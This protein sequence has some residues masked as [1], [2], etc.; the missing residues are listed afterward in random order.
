[1]TDSP[2]RLS[3]ALLAVLALA[4]C[5]QTDDDDSAID[6]DDAVEDDDDAVDDDDSGAQDDDDA[7]DDDD[8]AD[9]DDA[10]DDDDATPDDCVDG[11]APRALV[12][13]AIGGLVQF[14][15]DPMTA[16]L[17]IVSGQ[18]L[19]VW[20][21][22]DAANPALFHTHDPLEVGPWGGWWGLA[23]APWGF[24]AVGTSSEGPTEVF[25]LLTV[26]QAVAGSLIGPRINL[27]FLPSHV[28]VDGSLIVAV[29]G[30]GIGFYELGTIELIEVSTRT[31]EPGLG[32]IN[33]L[34]LDGDVAIVTSWT[35]GVQLVP[36]SADLP[37]VDLTPTANPQQPLAV[38]EGWLIPETS[39]FWQGSIGALE[40]LDL[41]Q[42]SLTWL[43][44]PPVISAADGEDGPFAAALH[45]GELFLANMESGTLRADWT[46][47]GLAIP[48]GTTLT[49]DVWPGGPLQP[50]R[51][52]LF[53]GVLILGTTWG[54]SVGLV[55]ICPP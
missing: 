2:L 54:S 28:A 30:M 7:V 24:A 25:H 40:L 48:V 18:Q 39:N 13:P 26:E 29:G 34:A 23:P 22:S 41:E 37:A 12:S 20:D 50:N 32:T 17:G 6:D 42:E 16:R 3:L 1:M 43:A 15:A 35:G 53:D 44:Q 36:S 11:W 46:T 8:S 5:P 52:D 55:E 4:G 49:A 9:D 21:L 38:P 47:E 45:E 33:G 27:P 14:A 19:E 31:F 10:V 51:A